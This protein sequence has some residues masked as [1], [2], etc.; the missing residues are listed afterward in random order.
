[1][2]TKINMTHGTTA[3]PPNERVPTNVIASLIRRWLVEHKAKSPNEM[4]NQH[5]S[6]YVENSDKD[7]HLTILA[8]HTGV[9]SRHLR[10]IMTGK[11]HIGQHRTGTY[12]E[13]D[14]VPFD[15]ADKIVCGTVGPLA[16][17]IE[18]L[19]EFYGPLSVKAYERHL[20]MAA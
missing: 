7:E 3:T 17:H 11:T 19:S 15:I 14:W 6:R 8:F 5:V 10:R 13:V 2:K 9:S 16:W 20:E 1:M 12:Q 4:G 18:P